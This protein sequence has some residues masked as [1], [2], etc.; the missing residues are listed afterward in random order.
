MK[1]GR[2]VGLVL[3]VGLGWTLGAC[4]V[5]LA[6][7]EATG[8]VPAASLTVTA[9]APSDTPTELPA[10][11]SE[12]TLAEPPTPTPPYP[13]PAASTIAHLP[14][15]QPLVLAWIHM[16]NLSAG[17][18]I[19]GVPDQMPH[20]LRTSDG[21]LHWTDVTPPE[22]AG[23][24]DGPW[25][26]ALAY[27]IDAHQVS[28][29]YSGVMDPMVGLIPVVVWRTEDGGS[30]WLPSALIEP[31]GGSGWFVP[32]GF[33]FLDDGFGWLMA[34][35]D[36]GMMHQ[37]IS[38]HTT[39]DGGA[40]WLRVV[41]PYGDQPVQSCPKTGLE[42][43]D[44]SYGWLTRDCG[45][46]IDQVTIEI[47][48]DGG[49]TWVSVPVP[50]PASLPSGFAYPY[51]CTPHSIHLTTAHEGSLAVS[52]R[53]YLETQAPGGETQADGP[54]ALYRTHDGGATWDVREYPGGEILWLDNARGLAL[55]R[56]IF[57]TENGGASWMLVH[58]VN[59]DGQFTFVDLQH[60]WAVAR[61]GG[62]VAL[63][64]TVNGGSTWSVLKPLSAP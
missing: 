44:A 35:I 47:T 4:R 55:G 36:A 3:V 39:R 9:P 43:A 49:S 57:R 8:T 33:G 48:Q 1:G 64:R 19:G 10:V 18:A 20:V 27:P 6:A 50:A 46:L 12:P 13:T 17:W 52:C 15:G 58:E 24:A 42:F 63:V 21:G 38:I 40:H 34:A 11:T 60:G 54:H 25:R 41:D 59:W 45:G 37:Y 26:D 53:R 22:A 23:P 30:T 31:P 28:V 61:D 16:V 2:G 32:S 51:L 5:P 7:E 29:V 14:G 62:E 56:K